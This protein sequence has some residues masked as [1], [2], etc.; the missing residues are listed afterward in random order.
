MNLKLTLTSN[1]YAK[2]QAGKTPLPNTDANIITDEN[3]APVGIQFE[4]HTKE[5]PLLLGQ[6]QPGEYQA[7]WFKRTPTNV[8]GA[9]EVREFMDFLLTGST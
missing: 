1:S 3:Q 5:S 7:V 9:G 2:F 8:S 6:L 4:D